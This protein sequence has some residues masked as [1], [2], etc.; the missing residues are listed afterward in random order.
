LFTSVWIWVNSTV[1]K[2]DIPPLAQVPVDG[3]IWS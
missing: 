3:Q 2:Y 1:E